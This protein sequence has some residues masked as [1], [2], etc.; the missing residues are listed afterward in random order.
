MAWTVPYLCQ[1]LRRAGGYTDPD[2][3]QRGG[4]ALPSQGG[5]AGSNPVGGTSLKKGP[6]QHKRW[7]GAQRLDATGT[8]ARQGPRGAGRSRAH[9]AIPPDTGRALPP[10]HAPIHPYHRIHDHPYRCAIRIGHPPMLRRVGGRSGV[11]EIPG[12]GR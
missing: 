3:R 8:G 11:R 7:V 10:D 1:S 6:D 12:E 2:L 4:Q 5:S 9:S